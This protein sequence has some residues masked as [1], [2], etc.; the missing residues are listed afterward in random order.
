V[1]ASLEDLTFMEYFS[2]NLPLLGAF[3]LRCAQVKEDTTPWPRAVIRSKKD[4]TLSG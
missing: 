3:L 2:P 1:G 4:K